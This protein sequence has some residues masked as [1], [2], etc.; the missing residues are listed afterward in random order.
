MVVS[1]DGDLQLGADAVIGG[2]Q[3]R[4]GEAC[5]LQIEQAAEAADFAIR[6]GTPRRTHRRFDLFDHQVAGVDIHTCITIGKTVLARLAH[7]SRLR[8][9]LWRRHSHGTGPDARV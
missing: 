3:N 2:H 1:V 6:A 5:G 8:W 4:I 9:F 7:G